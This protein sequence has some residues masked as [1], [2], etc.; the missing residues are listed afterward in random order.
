MTV[1]ATDDS[2][3]ALGSVRVIDQERIEQIIL[4][5]ADGGNENFAIGS[6]S[7]AFRRGLQRYSLNQRR[8]VQID[9]IQ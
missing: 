5:R 9:D 8:F 1:I 2:L 6:Y 4:A 7:D 3:R